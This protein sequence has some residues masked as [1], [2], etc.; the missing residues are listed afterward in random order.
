MLGS[1][2]SLSIC[3]PNWRQHRPTFESVTVPSVWQHLRWRR[4]HRARLAFPSDQRRL[5]VTMWLPRPPLRQT[6]LIRYRPCAASSHHRC[7][8][9]RHRHGKRQESHSSRHLPKAK[10]VA[11]TQNRLLVQPLS[12]LQSWCENQ[13]HLVLFLGQTLWQMRV[14][15]LRC[16]RRL[17]VSRLLKFNTRTSLASHHFELLHYLSAAGMA[18]KT[19]RFSL[20]HHHF[21][22]SMLTLWAARVQ[23]LR[24]TILMV[25]LTPRVTASGAVLFLRLG[26]R[27]MLQ[28]QLLPNA[29]QVRLNLSPGLLHQSPLLAA[30]VRATYQLVSPSILQITACVVIRRLMAITPQA[31]SRRG[32]R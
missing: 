5:C 6:T 22:L 15:L 16:L 31:Q 19:P 26:H 10:G 20:Y 4:N 3:A 17:Q 24:A 12:Q 1:A 9:L 8:W 13:T 11:V 23:E 32:E 7:R 18:S 30:V 25:S 29:T 2:T 27:P 28:R 21:S 14:H